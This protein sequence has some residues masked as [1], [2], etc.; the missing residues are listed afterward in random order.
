M[1]VLRIIKFRGKHI[2]TGVWLYGS[3]YD[4]DGEMYILPNFPGSAI[5]YED[6]QVDPN[7]VGEY[8]GRDD[9]DGKPLYEGDVF[10]V[11]GKYPKVIRYIPEWHSF[12]VA[13]LDTITDPLT[14]RWSDVCKY[15]QPAPNW[16]K[17]FK[18]EIR[19]IGNEYDNPELVR[20][21]HL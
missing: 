21:K 18:D 7:T 1:G 20:V 5:D 13:N 3:L 9:A 19:I 12:C 8:L 16:W 17:D 10:T 4:D 2:E 15:Q 6:Y 14:A 11:G